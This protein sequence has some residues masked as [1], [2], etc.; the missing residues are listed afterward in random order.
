[1]KITI[2]YFSIGL[3]TATIILLIMYIIID[4]SGPAVEN[5][6][7][8]E[9]SSA[10]EEKG[11]RTITQ[12]EFISYS[13]YLDEMKVEEVN[14]TDSLQDN[15]K[16]D[17]NKSKT[18]KSNSDKATDKDKKEKDTDKQQD[19]N[20]NTDNN[21]KEKD[22]DKEIKTATITVEQGNVSQHIGEKLEQEG[23]IKDAAEFTKYMED[24]NYSS[25]IQIG[26]FKVKSDMSLKDLAETF[27]TFPGTN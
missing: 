9:L 2:R 1:M 14:K 16:S 7:V 20:E 11:F 19:K 3:L 25:R 23:I 27:T 26:S 24:N 12:D 17:R 21:K 6:T 8:E 15:E 5:L 10:L 4:D 18:E 13:V 22:K